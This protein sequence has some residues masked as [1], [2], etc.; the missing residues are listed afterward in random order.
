MWTGTRHS[1][2]SGKEMQTVYA[3]DNGSDRRANTCLACYNWK[4]LVCF[5]ITKKTSHLVSELS[6]KFPMGDWTLLHNRPRPNLTAVL[7][8]QEKAGPGRGKEFESLVLGP[9]YPTAQGFHFFLP[10]AILLQ[11]R[12]QLTIKRDYSLFPTFPLILNF[13]WKIDSSLILHQDS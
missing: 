2:V 1:S 5:H 10:S 13:P 4:F 12:I 9:R 7:S 6:L 8:Y 11:Y 3:C